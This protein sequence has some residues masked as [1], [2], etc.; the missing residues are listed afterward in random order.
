MATLP[1]EISPNVPG[2]Y[3]LK[4]NEREIPKQVPAIEYF[5]MFPI[6]LFKN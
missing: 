6:Y 3:L 2:I 1:K 5:T 4:L